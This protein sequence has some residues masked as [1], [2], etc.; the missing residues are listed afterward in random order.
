MEVLSL[1]HTRQGFSLVELATVVAIIGIFVSIT[2]LV[3]DG[4]RAR[5]RETTNEADVRILNSATLQ[6]MMDDDARDPRD[7]NTASLRA[8]LED[9]HM[10]GW[11]ES[12][13]DSS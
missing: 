3:Y 1:C 10:S 7:H 6:W 12:P 11:P 4:T 5:A 8:E 2:I 13:T 9:S